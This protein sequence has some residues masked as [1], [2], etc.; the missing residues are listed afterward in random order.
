[1]ADDETGDGG[2][3]RRSLIKYGTV[4]AVSGWVVYSSSDDTPDSFT[5]VVQEDLPES[6]NYNKELTEDRHG[7][8]MSDLDH[9]SFFYSIDTTFDD[10]DDRSDPTSLTIDMTT[11][12]LPGHQ[13]EDFASIPDLRLRKDIGDIFEVMIDGAVGIYAVDNPPAR[14]PDRYSEAVDKIFATVDDRNNNTLNVTLDE[15]D[16]DQLETVYSDHGADSFRTDLY[17]E[18]LVQEEISY[19]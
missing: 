9:S 2:I 13:Y 16:L 1:M 12:A 7:T 11:Q 6:F 17:L 4:T 19:Y 8:R 18:K 15:T 3:S 5:E 10:I 14:E